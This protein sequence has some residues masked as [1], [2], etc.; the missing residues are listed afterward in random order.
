V[1]APVGDGR[2]GPAKVAEVLR[3]GDVAGHQVAVHLF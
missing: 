2:D 1:G 3:E